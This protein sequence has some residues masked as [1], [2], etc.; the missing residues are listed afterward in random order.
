VR[1]ENEYDVVVTHAGFS[2][3]NHYQAAKAAVEASRA[4]R[5]GGTLILVAN[6]TDVDP[7]GGP[8][9]RQVLP[10]LRQLGPDGFDRRILAADWKFIP[11]QWEVQMW[12]RAF[13]KL[14][15]AGR[16][17][18][19]APRVTGNVF[20]ERGLP[21]IDGGEGL[22]GLCGRDLA[23]AMVQRAMDRFVSGGRVA[24]L[25]DGPYVVPL[26][27]GRARVT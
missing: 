3:I 1:I 19:C 6:H 21:G 18:Y 14:G 23:E 27:A 7:V 16:L 10:L 22:T 24:V 26:L 20:V 25:A 15:P 8:N 5:R 4:V 17:I 2:G 12:A 13:R 11:E 9:Y